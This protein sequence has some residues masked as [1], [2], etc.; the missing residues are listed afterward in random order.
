[1]HKTFAKVAIAQPNQ[2]AMSFENNMNNIIESIWM[3]KKKGASYRLG[4]EL[5]VCGYTCED[6]FFEPDTVTH[7][8]DVIS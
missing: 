6:G 4:P 7:S 8:W 5:E 1:M 2:W 3:A